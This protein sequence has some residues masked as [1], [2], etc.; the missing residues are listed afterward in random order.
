MAVYLKDSPNLIIGK[1]LEDT[2][3]MISVTTLEEW[4]MKRKKDM[5]FIILTIP[6]TM[7]ILRTIHMM[8]ILRELGMMDLH[9]LKN[10]K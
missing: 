8:E 10:G 2:F 5:E 4:W 1:S 3:I 9:E 7:E 6:H